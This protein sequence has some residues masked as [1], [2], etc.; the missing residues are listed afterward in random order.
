MK[1]GLLWQD[2]SSHPLPDKVSKLALHFRNKTGTPP[3]VCYVNP[4]DLYEYNE[5]GQFTIDGVTVKP[6]QY[7]LP[8]KFW[9]GIEDV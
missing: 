6:N 1:E 8:C 5:G 3:N 2:H 4:D 7:I 9:I